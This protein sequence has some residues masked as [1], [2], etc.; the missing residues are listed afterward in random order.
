MEDFVQRKV[1]TVKI[2]LQNGEIE[3]EPTYTRYADPK[4]SP[5]QSAQ[6]GAVKRARRATQ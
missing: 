2:H 1:V 3:E 5:G 6:C 4:S